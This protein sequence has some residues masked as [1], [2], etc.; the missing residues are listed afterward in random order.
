MSSKRGKTSHC[1]FGALGLLLIGVLTLIFNRGPVVEELAQDCLRHELDLHDTIGLCLKG[2]DT[3]F[4]GR[5]VEH[6]PN[7][8]LK[9][10]VEIVEGR[11][12][13]LSRGWYENGQL[14]V[15]EHFVGGVSHGA[16]TRYY[17]SGAK[18]S[19]AQITDGEITGL[20]TQWH[21]N[22]RKAA[23]VTMMNGKANGKS[24]AWHRSGRLKSEIE[25]HA[26]EVVSSQS[27]KDSSP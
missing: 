26:G 4:T 15:E 16:R 5:L 1:I 2:T 6:F 8:T 27:F 14:E 13:G 10:A 17:Q 25:V 12:H 19:L 11:P 18:K 22:G 21:D 20:F 3:P 7:G 9:A 24:Q 23:E